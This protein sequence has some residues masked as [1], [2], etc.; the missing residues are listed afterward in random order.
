MTTADTLL[1]RC[2]DAARVPGPGPTAV[3]AVN[4]ATC[5]VHAGDRIA[6][7]GP[8]GSGKSTLLH[9]MADILQ[10]TAG[11]ISW[12][13]LPRVPARGQVG[14]VLPGHALV[15]A[16]SVAENAA[17]PLVLAG[18]PR[19]RAHLRALHC[20][21]VVAAAELAHKMPAELS[22][23]QAK[24]VAIART[25]AT[26]PRLIL[27]DDPTCDLDR[28][29]GREVIDVLFAAADE[30][31]AAL[32]V[33]TRDPAVADRLRKRWAM[34]EGRLHLRPR[35]PAPAKAAPRT[36][37]LSLP[38]ADG[39]S[40]AQYIVRKLPEV[41]L[42]FWIMKI[43]ATTLG[44][45]AGD[46]FA[47]TLR[48][49]YFLTTIVLFLMFVVTLVVQLRA[50]RYNPFF[51]WPV[52]VSTSMV[53][54]T[55]SD[56]MNRDA[57][58]KYLA[59]GM[60]TLGWGPQGLGL[61]YPAGAA[62]LISLLIAIFVAWK[63]TGQ[64]FVIRDIVTFRGEA[65]FW[66]AIL[67]SNTLGT[68]MGDFLSDSSGLGYAGSA[69]LITGVLLVLVILIRVP[70]VPNVVLFWIAFVLT[71]PLGATAGDFLTK[72]TAK[73]G[74]DLGT[75]GSSAVLLAILFAFMAYGHFRDRAR[76]A[77]RERIAAARS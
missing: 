42:A 59:K 9:L 51:Y 45:T 68:S 52:I 11:E 24:H 69:L 36:P 26:S 23:G 15:P 18:V 17:L 65:L 28:A 20:L 27:A 48:L 5:E 25:L 43:A 34:H 3:A 67:V 1:L 21:A 77:E 57:S 54:T 50:K 30:A 53:G 49:G 40:K 10:P 60:T 39:E 63:F 14:V 12:P 74:L 61:G 19:E 31:G 64:T 8:S 44:E 16:L 7:T 62:I 46:L 32:V 33:A 66:S 58:S 41:T 35:P 22:G 76:G 4:S 13:G 6:I 29:T 2:Q 38:E 71:R 72:P 75:A 73:G 37:A 70:F 55:V 56:F 47:Q